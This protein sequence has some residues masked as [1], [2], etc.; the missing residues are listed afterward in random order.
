MNFLEEKRMNDHIVN[1]V[2]EQRM[3]ILES[4]KWDFKKMSQDVMKRQYK[5]GHK[6]VSLGKKIP[7]QGTAPNAYPLRGQA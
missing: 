5:S 2:R 3:K 6:V 7:Q 4:Y 1:E